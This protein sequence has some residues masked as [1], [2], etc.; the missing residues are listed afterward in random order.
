MRSIVFSKVAKGDL[1]ENF[2][3]VEGIIKKKCW[4]QKGSQKN[5]FNII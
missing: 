4:D 5:L 3:G 1:K 2:Q